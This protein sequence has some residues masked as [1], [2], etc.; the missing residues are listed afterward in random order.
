MCQFIFNV[1]DIFNVSV[2]EAADCNHLIIMGV[3]HYI[4]N[5]IM[6]KELFGV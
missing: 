3:I 1:S 4:Q 6:I 2:Y 5:K